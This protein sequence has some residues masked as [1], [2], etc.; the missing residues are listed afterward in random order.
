MIDLEKSPAPS[1]GSNS[2]PTMCSPT[3]CH[4]CRHFGQ[5]CHLTSIFFRKFLI[6]DDRSEGEKTWQVDL[7]AENW[8]R[9][10]TS[11]QLLPPHF[12]FPVNF[13]RKDQLMIERW[14][15][16]LECSYY[17]KMQ[18]KEGSTIFFSMWSEPRVK[19]TCKSPLQG[20][21]RSS[22]T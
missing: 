12:S 1:G 14:N 15:P 7:E 8:T 21:A 5:C 16:S 3:L 2:G 17:V 18:N 22:I 20:N 6:D 9:E 10:K 13:P 19:V 4:L 11:V